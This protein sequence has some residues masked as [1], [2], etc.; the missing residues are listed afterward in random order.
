MTGT[1]PGTEETMINKRDTVS[2]HGLV[3]KKAK[4][5]N[6]IGKKKQTPQGKKNRE[7]H[8]DHSWFIS[9]RV[10]SLYIVWF[11]ANIT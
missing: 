3:G 6:E 1:V 4:E 11:V 10:Y 9:G 5:A 8:I 7:D 2:I